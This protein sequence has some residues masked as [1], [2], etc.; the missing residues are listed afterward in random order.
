MSNTFVISD[1]HFG[2]R[3][4]V[5]FQ[6][7]LREG[8]SLRPWDDVSEMDEA[9]IDNW[10]KAVRPKD[11]VYHLGDFCMNKGFI[12]I[13]QRLNGRKKLVMGNHEHYKAETYLPFFEDVMGVKC[14]DGVVMTHIPVHES[15]KRRFPKANIHGHLHEFTLE[16]PW[17]INVCVETRNYTPVSYD[18]LRKEFQG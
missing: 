6:S 17:Y 7:R 18:E 16:D 5:K 3:G 11:L 8:E 2:H 10:N 14:M 12:H 15:Q 9:L 4:I 1:T 13:A